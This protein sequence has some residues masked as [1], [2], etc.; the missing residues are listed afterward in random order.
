MK[1]KLK[2]IVIPE[3]DP[4]VNDVLGRRESAK[5]LTNLL[6]SIDEP[7]VISIDSP[8]GTGKSTF[9][10]MWSQSLENEGFPILYY[11]AWEHDFSD[12]AFLSLIS[13]IDSGMGN[14]KDKF[15]LSDETINKFEQVKKMSSRF[16]KSAL[17]AILKMA[18]YGI[19]DFKEVT[20]DTI[21]N[22]VEE[23]AKGEIKRYDDSKKTLTAFKS[24]LSEFV[25]E[26]NN[27]EKCKNKPLIIFIDE[28]DRCRPTFAIEILEK[29]KHFFNINK[30][31][32]ILAI[33]KEQIGNSISSIYGIKM[34]TSG[35]LKRF[36][37]LE[38]I[39][40]PPT[41]GSFTNF[42]INQYEFSDFFEKRIA[43]GAVDDWEQISFIFSE[44]TSLFNLSLREQLQ[45]FTQLSLAIRMTP[46]NN[47][48][49]GIPL[50]FLIILKLVNREQYYDFIEHRIKGEEIIDFLKKQ[51]GSSELFNKHYGNVLIVFLLWLAK[52]EANNNINTKPYEEII[53]NENATDDDKFKASSIL[54]ILESFRGQYS[55]QILKIIVNKIE[56]L[57]NFVNH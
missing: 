31:I 6:L 10:K 24:K 38:Y 20:E 39:L 45:C 37:D 56:I 35:Y 30:I 2:E 44:M 17:P 47:Y 54:Q 27:S 29:A 33:D 43:K 5:V 23:I 32:F 48:L 51:N 22:F 11:N 53:K 12:D 14:L 41:K 46:I 13:E 16:I 36:I 15:A 34:K 28:L 3:T 4:F 26:L 57:E 50:S 55:S 9:I 42:L 18:T 7:F 40:P 49:Y 52:S 1:L 21:A 8:W 19:V 25:I